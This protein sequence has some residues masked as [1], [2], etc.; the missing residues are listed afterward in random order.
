MI[1]FREWATRQFETLCDTPLL[2]LGVCMWMA[3]LLGFTPVLLPVWFKLFGQ[4]GLLAA[5]IS[6]WG[7]LAVAV[8]GSKLHKAKS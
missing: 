8:I 1:T 6:F 2:Y 5:A 3:G 4:S 7:G